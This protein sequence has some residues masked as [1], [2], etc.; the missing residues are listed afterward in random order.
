M[1]KYS[2]ELK[3]EVVTE[4]LKGAQGYKRLAKQSG[5]PDATT[6][7]RWVKAYRTLGRAGITR[8]TVKTVYPVQFKLDTIQFMLDTGASYPETAVQFKLNN[9]ALIFHWMKAFQE[10]GVEGLQPKPKGR[11]SMSGKSNKQQKKAPKQL[12]REEA[13]ERENE[14]LRLENTYLKKLKAFREKNAA[15]EKCR[16]NWHSNSKQQDSD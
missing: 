4:Y 3:L 13:L 2:D 6:V 9:P 8:K 15:H 11:P 7:K 12:S 16:Q 1:V 5:I 10:H 14:L